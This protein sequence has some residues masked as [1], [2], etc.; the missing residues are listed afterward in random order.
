MSTPQ[1]PD[2]PQPTTD[3][4]YDPYE[5]GTRSDPLLPDH[6]ESPSDTDTI[7]R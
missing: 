3:D 6:R 5:S 2:D 1:S 7:F 4:G